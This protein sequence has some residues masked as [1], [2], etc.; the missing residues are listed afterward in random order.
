MNVEM[1][2]ETEVLERVVSRVRLTDSAFMDLTLADLNRL[3]RERESALAALEFYAVA[4]A[5]AW[6]TDRGRRAQAVL[7]RRS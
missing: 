1:D 4:D 5:E 6:V 2:F 7:A 3:V